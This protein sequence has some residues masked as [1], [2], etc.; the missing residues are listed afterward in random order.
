M[1]VLQAQPLKCTNVVPQ[2]TG[3]VLLVKV[4]LVI[5]RDVDVDGSEY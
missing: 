5:A 2:I 1:W 4:N 3:C